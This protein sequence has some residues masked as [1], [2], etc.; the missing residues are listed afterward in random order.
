VAV[1]EATTATFPLVWLVAAVVVI[2]IVAIAILLI[3]RR[4]SARG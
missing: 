2:V 4:S 3:Q 1:Q